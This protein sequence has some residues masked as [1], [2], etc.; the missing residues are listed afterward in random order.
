MCLAEIGLLQIDRYTLDGSNRI[1]FSKNRY[2]T[3]YSN[4]SYTY[5]EIMTADRAICMD[6]VL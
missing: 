3:L 6:D 2:I 5:V 4:V 1:K